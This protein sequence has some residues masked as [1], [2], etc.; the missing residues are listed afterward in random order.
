[1]E[2]GGI[3]PG[4]LRDL[5]GNYS[6]GER[7][8]SAGDRGGAGGGGHNAAATMENYYA[9]SWGDLGGVSLREAPLG[10]IGSGGGVGGG[11]GGGG[12]GGRPK[13]DSRH[14]TRYRGAA[15]GPETTSVDGSYHTQ[16]QGGG[17]MDGSGRK[18]SSRHGGGGGVA[19][20][21]S[22]T[23]SVLSQDD[24]GSIS[25]YSLSNK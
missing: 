11:G 21:D 12:G 24:M 10:P 5:R 19:Y 2:E 4:D 22:D 9:R 13:G 20:D 17:H 15:T 16:G 25:G 8:E 3:T 23:L 14:D 7:G 1:M 18:G 6:G